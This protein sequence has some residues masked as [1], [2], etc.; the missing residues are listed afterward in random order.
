MEPYVNGKALGKLRNGNYIEY[1]A[2]PGTHVVH[3]RYSHPSAG[4]FPVWAAPPEGASSDGSKAEFTFDAGKVYYVAYPSQKL[5]D[6]EKGRQ[7]L[8]QCDVVKP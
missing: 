4:A 7:E 2:T 1:L 5:V 3:F 6:A 8:S